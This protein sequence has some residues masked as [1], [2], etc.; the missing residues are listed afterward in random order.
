MSGVGTVLADDPRL[1]VRL[2]DFHG[3]QPLRVILDSRLRTPPGSKL[4]AADARGGEVLLLTAA[5]ADRS[6]GLELRRAALIRCGA[7][8]EEVHAAGGYLDLRS[9]ARKL[10]E[11]EANEVL[12]EAGP[13]L[14]GRLLTENLADELLLYVAP[15]LL[16]PRARALLDVP[17]PRSLQDALG[18]SLLEAKRFGDDVRMLMRPI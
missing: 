3:P 12:V 4:F 2:P 8:I 15:K 11:L 17:E 14:A 16:G 10:A 1:N 13:T 7:R 5:G 9:V 18:F 6:D